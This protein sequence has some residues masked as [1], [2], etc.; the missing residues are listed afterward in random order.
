MSAGELRVWFGIGEF[1]WDG[2]GED[3]CAAR[4]RWRKWR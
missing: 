4:A 1:S 3:E 2:V